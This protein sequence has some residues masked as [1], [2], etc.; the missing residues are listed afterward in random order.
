M[1]YLIYYDHEGGSVVYE[2][3][4]LSEC[5]K[6]ASAINPVFEPRIAVDVS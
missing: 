1:Y 4:T 5:Q 2:A 6:E 3:A